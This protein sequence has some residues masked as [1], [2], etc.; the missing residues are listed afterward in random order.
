MA[1]VYQDAWDSRKDPDFTY[2]LDKISCVRSAYFAHVLLSYLVFLSGIGAFA[3]RLFPTRYRW[4]HSWCGRGYIMSML[5]CAGTSLLIHNSGLP[6]AVLISFVWVLGG[7]CMGWVLINIHQ[8]RIEAGAK[9][10]VQSA[11]M[12]SG[13]DN[14]GLDSLLAKEKLKIMHGRT[15]V[16]RF[17]SCKTWHACLMFMSWS[18]IAARILTSNQSGSFTCHTYA[19]WKEIDTPY[20]GNHTNAPLTALD[21]HDPDYHR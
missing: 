7:L 4:L 10:Q 12:A 15:L 19:V 18:N 5:W 21:I 16:Q 6:P 1:E 20:G 3:T 8:A 2:Q 9:A 14:E 11:I 17:L 13:L